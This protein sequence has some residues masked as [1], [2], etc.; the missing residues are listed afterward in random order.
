MIILE[1]RDGA[2]RTDEILD[3]HIELTGRQAGLDIFLDHIKRHGGYSTS[4]AHDVKFFCGLQHYHR[5][6]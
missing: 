6:L 2:V 1:S 3:Q 4:L 5:V